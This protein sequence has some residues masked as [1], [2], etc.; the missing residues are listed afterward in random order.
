MPTA[1]R[2]RRHALTPASEGSDV[3]PAVSVPAPTWRP[4]PLATSSEPLRRT[5]GEAV[6]PGRAVLRRTITATSADI[7]ATRRAKSGLNRLVGTKD[8][9]DKIGKLLDLHRTKTDQQEQIVT[10]TAI[11]G[12][13]KEW[14]AKHTDP[15]EAPTRA[16]LEDILAEASRDLGRAQAQQRYV[17]DMRA[18]DMVP[19]NRGRMAHESTATPF[20]QHLNT[21]MAAKGNA[22][23][24]SAAPGKTY[25]PDHPA[26]AGAEMI[27][28]AGLTEAEITA[29]K[30]YTG[31][32]Y[33]FINPA[34]ARDTEWLD[35]QVPAM[36]KI[37]DAQASAVGQRTVD[38]DKM[39][40]EGV[41]HTGV[42]MQGLAKME[43]KKGTTYR[44][45]RMTPE[46]FDETYGKK[47]HV[48]YKGFTSTGL[49]ESTADL[50]ARGGGERKP[51][52][53]QT[54]S[55]KCFFEVNDARDIKPISEIAVENEWLLLPGASFEITKIVNVKQGD[56]G[57]PGVTPAT[58]WK[59]VHLKQ[60]SPK[61][62]PPE[63]PAAPTAPPS[64]QK[65]ANGDF[66]VPATRR[67]RAAPALPK[68]TLG[69]SSA[70]AMQNLARG[71][72]QL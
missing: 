53:D 7:A 72:F 35:K 10:L 44:G 30:L 17:N 64:M 1:A 29:I 38:T 34:T 45:A 70:L 22:A 61:E 23:I 63:K 14:L 66:A 65:L 26:R 18:G 54:V 15:K 62:V 59:E 5:A 27:R 68:P 39:R 50:Y 52:P 47:T 48:V 32:A 41:V 28:A 2:L 69:P 42:A 25:H 3:E 56:P 37:L 46:K 6:A 24:A 31:S 12:L 55:V 9:L 20:T 71:K 43:V 4:A 58:A 8:S 13:T 11:T 49:L 51:D 57:K 19:T 40:E 36:Q 60:I 16:L 33:L 67:P 21:G